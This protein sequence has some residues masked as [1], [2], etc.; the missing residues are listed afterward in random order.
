MRQSLTFI[1][2]M[3]E[4][5]QTANTKSCQMLLRA[6]YIRQHANGTYTYLPLAKRVLHKIEQIVREELEERQAIELELPSIQSIDLWKQSGRL[7][8]FN[9]EWIYLKDR[10]QHELV[11]GPSIELI[12][13]IVRD[14]I[15]TY[16]K[17][18]LT[19]FQIQ[20]RFCDEKE[21]RHDLFQARE[22]LMKDAYSFHENEE[23][24]N[25]SFEHMISAYE[26]IFSRL[27]LNVHIVKADS[28]AFGDQSFEFVILNNNGQEMI[29]FSNQSH[30][31]ANAQIAEVAI[32]Y[33][34][35]NE[36]LKPIEKVATPNVQT[37]HELCD[38][39]QFESTKCIKSLVLNVD[40][41][42]IVALVRGDHQ[43][44]MIKIMKLLNASNVQ[45][46][47]EEEIEKTLG[48]STGSIGP[49]K[50]PLDIKVVADYGIKSI[51]NGVS[52]ANENG[53]HYIN[54]NPN[55]D[56]A[57]NLYGDIRYIE[58][59]DPSPDGKGIIRLEKGIGIGRVTKLN[60]LI[61]EKMKA[62]VTNQEGKKIPMHLASYELDLT[63]LF[64]ILAEQY[65]D[66]KGFTW[67]KHLAPYD[68][69]LMAVNVADEAQRNL[70]D[71]LYNILTTYRYDVLYDDRDDRAGI[72]FA[73]SDLIGLPIRVTIG[74]K[75]MEGIVEVKIR[76]TGETFECAKEELIDR[77]NEFYRTQ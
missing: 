77:L 65:Y 13:S 71:Q 10:N 69:H 21:Y 34:Q 61:A 37:I 11:M 51:V 32:E 16:K 72:K 70:A 26:R 28:G 50:L 44:N 53:Y 67:P 45:F 27:G 22:F 57:I 74:N 17:L 4:V 36:E 41:E 48:C 7:Q 58:E 40:G 19:L 12:T 46:A 60:T 30:Y 43:L 68:L 47:S 42:I 33:E 2:T 56:F 18:P 64:G 5:P 29:A 3:R 59:G 25:G 23:S 15:K 20:R 9:K 39:L 54:V 24:L 49:I 6:G 1:P 52:G 38:F 75:A 66:E 73:D 14:E 76:K 63:R 8:F 62:Y 35:P 55:R 31:V